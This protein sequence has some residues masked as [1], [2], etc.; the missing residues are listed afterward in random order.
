MVI[1][2]DKVMTQVMKKALTKLVTEAVT[3]GAENRYKHC[4]KSCEE[5]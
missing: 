1:N 4:G 3:K 5:K 2:I